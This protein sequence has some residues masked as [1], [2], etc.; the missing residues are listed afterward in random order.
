MATQSNLKIPIIG[1]SGVGKSSLLLR[2]TDDAFDPE[3]AP[4]IGVDF[5]AKTISVDGHRAK[6]SI[7]DTAGQERFRTLTPSFYRGA[8][9]IIIVYDVTDRPTFRHLDAWMDEVETFATKPDMKMILVGNKTD[10]EDRQVSTEEGR[11]FARRHS[12]LF[13]EA[14]AK[15]KEG[16][17]IA[18]K[19]LVE[20]ILETPGLWELD[21]APKQAVNLQ[22]GNSQPAEGRRRGCRC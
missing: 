1:D 11:R 18:F 8:H 17:E 6:L 9:G 20:K 14:S 16:V 3:Q 22:G 4:T 5:R 13:I 2:Y 12:M 7:W 10:K 21:A 15:T 19:E